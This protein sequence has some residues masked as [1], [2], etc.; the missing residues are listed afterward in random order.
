M[1]SRI[2]ALEPPTEGDYREGGVI[3]VNEGI[4]RISGTLRGRLTLVCSNVIYVHDDL[5]YANGTSLATEDD[6]LAII[7][8]NEIYFCAKNISF[9]GIVFSQNKSIN[10]LFMESSPYHLVNKGASDKG[11]FRLTGTTITAIPNEVS[12]GFL[13]KFNAFDN[14]LRQYPPPQLPE[15]PVL[16]AW[17]LF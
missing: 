13:D 16:A 12:N 9:N 5:V 4:A 2:S 7:A 15:K 1:E 14:Y 3:F 8:L 10:G 11:T 17:S 6:S